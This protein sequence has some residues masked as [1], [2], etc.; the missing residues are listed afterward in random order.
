MLCKIRVHNKKKK[1]YATPLGRF[2][3]YLITLYNFGSESVLYIVSELRI[4][5]YFSCSEFKFIMS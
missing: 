3:E 5:S 1:G 2:K 4:R